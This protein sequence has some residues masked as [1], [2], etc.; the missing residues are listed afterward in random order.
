MNPIASDPLDRSQ[1]PLDEWALT[2]AEFHTSTQGRTETLFAVGNGYLGMRGNFEEGHKAYAEG[3]F[4]N[5]FHDTWTIRHAEE[6]YGFARVGQTIVNAPDA[7]VI[8]LYVD[9]EPFVVA[10]ADTIEY[11]RRLDFRTGVLE[12]VVEWRTPS[13]KRV[14][15]RSRRLVSFTD[16]HL[17]VIDYEVTMLDSDA[18][19]LISSQIL[20]RQD[21]VDEFAA[22]PV[23]GTGSGTGTSAAGAPIADPRKANGFGDRVLLPRFKWIHEGRYVLGYR[24]ANSGMTIAVGAE[25]HLETENDWDE[26]AQID[27][28]IAKQ[29]YRVHAKAG[30]RIRL[31]KTIAYHT[32]STVP[33]TELAD[34]ANRTL[35]RI[36]ETPIEEVFERQREWLDDFWE[37]ADIVVAGQPDVQQAIRWNLFQL[38]QSTARTDGGGIAAKG[39]S[40]SGY[41]GHYFWDTEIYVL[42]FL[43]YTSP[44]VARNALRFRHGMLDAAR[45]RAVELNQRGAL[46]PWRTING[47]ESSAYYAAG[48]AQY[49]IDA[50]ISH[51]LSQYVAATGDEDFLYRG[52]IDI[53]VETAR[54]WADLGFWRGHGAEGET[55]HIHGVTGPDEYTTVVNDN[56]FTNVMARANLRAAVRQTRKMKQTDP[57]AYARMVKRLD[58]S[59]DEI[60]EWATAAEAMHVLFDEDLGIHPQDSQFLEKEL[61]DLEN[62]PASKRPLL[63]HFHPLVI[64]RFQVIKQADVVLALFLQGDEF[65]TEE[66]RADFEYYDALTTGDSTL[67]ASTQSIIAAE[68]GYRELALGYFRA[69]LFVDLGDLHNN[70]ADGI[71]VASTGGVWSALTFGFGGMRDYLGKFTFDPRLPEE[72]DSLVFHVCIKGSLIEVDLRQD[73]MTFTIEKGGSVVVYVRGERVEVGPGAPVTVALADDRPSIEG[74]PTTSDIEGTVRADGS[75]ITASMPTIVSEQ[76]EPDALVGMD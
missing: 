36:R 23:N 13:G 56:L 7:R 14:L 58:L 25:H 59:E 21:R 67:S 54:M 3:T 34:R 68:V 41:G 66:K 64:Y 30:Q 10:D 44:Q 1:F 57:S 63:L 74:A 38:A 35:D 46:F 40:G 76:G 65:T 16:R 11:S 50:D 20:N 33:T 51:A 8:R 5:G 69:A 37:R 29:V 62:T 2:E 15:I 24:T 9:D 12:R 6:A 17:A 73:R 22:A 39:V 53:L 26:S 28:D 4:I 27:D 60:L 43:T 72:W 32:S 42:P 31:V 55:F 75:V 45:D 47:L 70:T 71:H 18:S 52:A 19:V 49:H 61:W 48:T